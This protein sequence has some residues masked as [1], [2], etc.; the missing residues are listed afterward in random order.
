M[1]Y[2]A[3]DKQTGWIESSIAAG[4]L[5][6]IAG[7][8]GYYELVDHRAIADGGVFG[9]MAHATLFASLTVYAL[10]TAPSA[11]PPA[12]ICVAVAVLAGLL[13]RLEIVPTAP[14]TALNWIFSTAGVAATWFAVHLMGRP[15]R[16]TAVAIAVILWGCGVV[17]S[18][19]AP[20]EDGTLSALI[21]PLSTAG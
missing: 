10:G 5:V 21:H 12:L 11:T 14:G 8:L 20:P 16:D 13:E 18:L 2:L 4:V 17:C 1:T 6:L 7:V 19:Q 15:R 9:G 3:H